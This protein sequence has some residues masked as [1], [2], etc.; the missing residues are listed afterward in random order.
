[1][2]LPRSWSYPS[3]DVSTTIANEAVTQSP[4]SVNDPGFNLCADSIQV[5]NIITAPANSSAAA[6][7]TFGKPIQNTL[8]YDA[9]LGVFVQVTAASVATFAQGVG[10]ASLAGVGVTCQ[11]VVTNTTGVNYFSFGAYVPNNYWYQL[12]ATQGNAQSVAA[13]VNAQW[14]PV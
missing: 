14:Q 5:P 3:A 13:S 10:S 8:G 6:S 12:N 7:I 11:N 4:N 2:A 1:M 9:Y